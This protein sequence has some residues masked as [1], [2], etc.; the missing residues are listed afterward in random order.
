[1]ESKLKVREGKIHADVW[2]V[3]LPLERPIGTPVGPF[4]EVSCVVVRL[5]DEAGMAG[6]GYALAFDAPSFEQLGQSVKGL[7][8][9]QPLQLTELLRIERTADDKGDKMVRKAVSAI[10][11]ASWDLVGRQGGKSCADLW[12]RQRQ[13]TSVPAYAS[14]L[15]LDRSQAQLIEEA[16]DLRKA[17]YTCVKMRGGKAPAEDA[18][19]FDAVRSVYAE[20]RSVAIDFFFQSDLSRTREFARSVGAAPMWIEDPVPYDVIHEL[21]ADDGIAAGEHCETAEGL[22]K[23][24][25]GGISRLILDVE[26]LGG[27]LR[28]LETARTLQALGCQVGSH[29][30]VHESIHLLAA[31][32]ESMPVEMLDWWNPLFNETPS[33]DA[34]GAYAVRGPGLGRT[35]REDTLA[36][37]GRI[38]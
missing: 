37:Y 7:L 29:M 32:P 9:A 21:G 25:A 23:L 8:A 6:C 16:G 38:V 20:S 34:G 24:R 3:V 35:L 14:A 5:R 4:R 30:F 33:P 17:G 1:M 28:F 31:L 22:L 36:R 11:L 18:L 15:F 26:Y 27:P 19:R 12:G 2:K 13:R 10:S